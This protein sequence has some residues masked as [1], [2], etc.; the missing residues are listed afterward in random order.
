MC[1][2]M[3]PSINTAPHFLHGIHL[4]VPLIAVPSILFLNVSLE[5]QPLM[6]PGRK[7]IASVLLVLVTR[8]TLSNRAA[9]L[10]IHSCR[11]TG[12]REAMIP[13]SR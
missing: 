7:V 10:S 9:S 13:S 8:L 5:K 2:R 4:L 3:D 6:L 1:F 11:K 12:L